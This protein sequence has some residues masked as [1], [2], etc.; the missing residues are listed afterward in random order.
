MLVKR[1][2]LVVKHGVETNGRGWNQA[3][4]LREGT[5]KEVKSLVKLRVRAS[6]IKD[7]LWYTQM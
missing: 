1:I 5:L 4:S 6:N 3:N 2:I 7:K